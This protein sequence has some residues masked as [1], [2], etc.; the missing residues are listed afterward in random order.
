MGRGLTSR[1]GIYCGACYVYRAQ[2]DGGAFLEVVS[3]RL[4]VP[5]DEVRCGGCTGPE[6]ELWRNCKKCEVLPCLNGR[7]IEFCYMCPEFDEGSCEKYERI[8]RFAS[9]RGE[10]VRAAMERIRAGEAEAWLEE[11]DQKWRC[12]HCQGNISWYEEICHHCNEPIR[13]DEQERHKRT[14]ESE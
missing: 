3:E 8:S 11:Q 7:G 4:G 2:E 10:D 14:S 6:E 13:K 9:E 5:P 12:P 1:C